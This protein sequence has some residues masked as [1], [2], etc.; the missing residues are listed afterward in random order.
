LTLHPGNPGLQNSLSH[1]QANLVKHAAHATSQ[2]T[3]HGQSGEPHGHSGDS[4]GNS[5]N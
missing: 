3:S 5:G 1:L 4:H 2:G